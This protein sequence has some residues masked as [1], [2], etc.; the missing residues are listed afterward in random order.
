MII[1]T[2]L[3]I[4]SLTI[5]FVLGWYIKKLLNKLEIFTDGVINF[6]LRLESLSNHLETVHEL[7]MFYGEPV[8]QQLIKHMKVT[9]LQI[10]DFQDSFIVSEG[11]EL[12]EEQQKTEQQDNNET[13][14]K[15]T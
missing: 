4:V 6:K 7:E 15:E 11:E 12:P 8:L 2:T 14:D 9:V 5:N 10:K 3:T 13:G 1:L